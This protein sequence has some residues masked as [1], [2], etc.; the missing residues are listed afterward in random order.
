[1]I[2]AHLTE[3]ELTLNAAAKLAGVSFPALFAAIHGDPDALTVKNVG[4]LC[5]HLGLPLSLVAPRLV[6]GEP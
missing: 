3:R 2:V 6:R 4:A 1:L 5:S